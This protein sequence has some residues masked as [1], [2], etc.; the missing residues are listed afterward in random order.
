MLTE[1]TFHAR[2][3]RGE[4]DLEALVE[5]I[6]AADAVDQLQENVDINK[7]RNWSET[8]GLDAKRDIHLWEDREGRVV[9]YAILHVRPDEE[10]AGGYLNCQVHPEAR[11]SGIEDDL[12][13]W[14]EERAKEGGREHELPADVRPFTN[15]AD[16]YLN[17]QLEKHGY[18]VVRYFF[19]MR[20]PLKDGDPIPEPSFPE[21]YTVRHVA[22]D[23]DVEKWVEMFNLSF[24]DHWDFHP[25]TVERRKFRMSGPTYRPD[26]DLI[27]VAPDGTFAAF[28]LCTIYDDFNE[29]N[30]V[31]EGWID[32]LGTRRGFRH[33]GLGRAMLLSGLKKLKDNDIEDAMLGVD[34]EN[35][36]G[37]LGLY[38]RVGFTKYKTGLAYR[39]IL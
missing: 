37:A 25:A 30:H 1:T 35:P 9:A 8:P 17:S 15:Q 31:S 16:T 20:R 13:A 38:E 22:N 23:E 12:F 28:C 14:V 33:I 36:T 10:Y 5:L 29:R 18:Q 19:Q 27:A 7:V 4:E 2:P 34:A 26:R 39:K 6:N 24:I 21:G 32:V 11:E 3:F